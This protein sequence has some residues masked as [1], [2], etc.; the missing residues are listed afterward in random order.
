MGKTP[1]SVVLEARL[2]AAGAD[3]LRTVLLERIELDGDIILD[4]SEVSLIDTPAVHVLL[5][6]ARSCDARGKAMKLDRPSEPFLEA[7]Q[8]LGLDTEIQNW[9][10]AN[11]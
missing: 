8:I 10:I 5:G 4:A 11:V 6:A 3:S 7:F 1:D 9:G 2:D